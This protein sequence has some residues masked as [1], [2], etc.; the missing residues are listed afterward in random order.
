MEFLATDG[1][2][3]AWK[4]L[5]PGDYVVTGEA[6]DEENDE[7]RVYLT[8]SAFETGPMVEEMVGYSIE[9]DGAGQWEI[10]RRSSQLALA[11]SVVYVRGDA[12]MLDHAE[13]SLSA[14]GVYRLP[15]GF[16]GMVGEVTIESEMGWPEVWVVGEPQIRN[17]RRIDDS[18]GR[19][20]YCAVRP[21]SLGASAGTTVQ[22]FELLVCPVPDL[23]YVLSFPYSI[24]P[25]E[26]TEEAPYPLGDP[27]HGETVMESCLA[28]A[29][30]QITDR[31]GAHSALFRERLAASIEHDLRHHAP[32][33]LGYNGDGDTESLLRGVRARGSFIVTYNGQFP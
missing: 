5:A 3:N 1:R 22:R 25:P 6:Y 2:F 24:V 16:G 21:C 18:P 13:F 11:D 30:I 9:V 4:D 10:L 28:A 26:L 15:T 32:R 20:R 12:S 14:D 23:T 19:P 31:P 8:L 33:Y 27:F 17:L 7:T 29:E